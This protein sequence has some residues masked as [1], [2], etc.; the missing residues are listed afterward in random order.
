MSARA[1]S[2]SPEFREHVCFAPRLRR[3]CSPR[4]QTGETGRSRRCLADPPVDYE[5]RLGALFHLQCI[6][7][8]HS[9]RWPWLC[10]AR[11]VSEAKPA[12]AQTGTCAPLAHQ[13][14]AHALTAAPAHSCARRRALSRRASAHPLPPRQQ[15]RRSHPSRPVIRGHPPIS[16]GLHLSAPGRGCTSTPV[17]M[18][19]R[20]VV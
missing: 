2:R 20:T 7:F 12:A 6:A 10:A 1:A 13:S 14:H 4:G 16:C 11:V 18:R 3:N 19:T 9:Q 5:E 17:V 15:P 8:F